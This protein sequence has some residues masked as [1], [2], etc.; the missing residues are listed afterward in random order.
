M[1]DTLRP[2]LF[3]AFSLLTPFPIPFSSSRCLVIVYFYPHDTYSITVDL[4]S[5]LLVFSS[6]GF[7]PLSR[8]GGISG[9]GHVFTLYL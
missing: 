4:G 5:Y 2:G 7:S 8:K 9:F 3:A 6:S 1:Y